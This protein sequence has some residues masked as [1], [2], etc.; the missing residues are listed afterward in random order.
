MESCRSVKVCFSRS[1]RFRCL[2]RREFT[3]LSNFE[4][5]KSNGNGSLLGRQ[6]LPHLASAKP[7]VLHISLMQGTGAALLR[8]VLLSFTSFPSFEVNSRLDLFRALW[9]FKLQKVRFEPRH[10]LSIHQRALF[11]EERAQ[12]SSY[13]FRVLQSPL[14]FATLASLDETRPDRKSLLFC[15]SS[16]SPSVQS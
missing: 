6:L 2:Q 16:S 9:L 15:C 12:E 13:F 1:W 7:R 3:V 11:L 10:R 8:A 4:E 14:I 5:R